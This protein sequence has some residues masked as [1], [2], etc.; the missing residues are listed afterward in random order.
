MLS[1]GDLAPDFDLPD[2][3]GERHQLS[4]MVKHGPVVLFFYPKAMTSGCTAEACSF[5]DHAKEFAVFDAQRVGISADGVDKQAQFATKNDLDYPLLSDEDK[6]VAK[7]FGVK[8]PGPIFNKRSTFVIGRDRKVISSMQQE[9]K[10]EA[11]ID[12]ALA[13]LRQAR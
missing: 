12:G 9:L 2:H 11:H 7:A 5:R 10:M 3:N 8:R 4:E 6:T 1:A 13:A